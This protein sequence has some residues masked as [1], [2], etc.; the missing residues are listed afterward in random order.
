[1]LNIFF[2][3]VINAAKA[4][5]DRIQHVITGVSVNLYMAASPQMIKSYAAGDLTRCLTLLMKTSK[6]SFLLVFVMSFPLI[7]NMDAILEF[8]L[9]ADSHTPYMMAF[10]KLILI[11]CLV[12]TLE[13]PISSII[14][15]TGDIKRYQIWVGAVT[16]SY[17]P[18]TAL[19]L[20]MGATPV[21]TLIILIGI[22]A[23]AQVV[24]LVVAHKQVGLP[25]GQY[26][27]MVLI[28]LLRVSFIALPIYWVLTE[29]TISGFWTGLICRT[30]I[31]AVFGIATAGLIGLD[32]SDRGMIKEMLRS[33]ISRPK[34]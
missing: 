22:M 28:P 20:W 10:C 15:A 5:A 3:P 8:W 11:Y 32:R 1:M 23:V 24:R 33:K 26:V 6:I 2:G 13:P 27:R 25:Y 14:Q 18:I 16:L 31:G 21:M 7:C 30:L 9:G 17:I 29:W 19:V 12:L 34:Q 4:I